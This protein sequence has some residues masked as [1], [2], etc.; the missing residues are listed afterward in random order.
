MNI[1][2]PYIFLVFGAGKQKLILVM[3]LSGRGIL[4][5]AAGIYRNARKASP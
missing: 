2:T 4:V 1:L 3:G 5:E